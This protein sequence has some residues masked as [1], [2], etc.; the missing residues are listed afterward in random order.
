MTEAAKPL[1]GRV[2]LVTGGARNIGRAIALALAEAGADVAVAARSDRTA[3][4][5]V[6]GEIAA[7]GTRGLALLGDV[8][9]EAD[10]A[11]LV[12]ETAERLGRLDILVN[13]AAVRRETPLLETTFDDWRAVMATALDGPFLL[14]R[15]AVPHLVA[16]G[17]GAIVNI[18]GLTA[19]TGARNRAHVV[20]AKA[21]L[22]GLTKALA[23]ELG[24]SGVT[25]NLVSPGLIETQRGSAS[26]PAA[27]S[28]HATHSTLLGRRGT[29]EEVAAAVLFLC[30]PQAR[31]VTGQTIHVNGGA[32]L[33]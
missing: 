10:A 28:H 22:D 7:L 8:G 12:A 27:P 16:G 17:A 33:P 19:Y 30:G 18:G 32:F 6:A 13:N 14:A 29:P 25:V 15:A 20:A 9:N 21:G 3:A 31:Y 24:T 11:R 1:A 5:A 23:H 2:A 26:S 4:E